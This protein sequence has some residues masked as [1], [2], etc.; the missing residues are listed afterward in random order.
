[1]ATGPNIASIGGLMGDPAR[2]NILTSLMSGH[3]LT[4][5]ELAQ[6]ASIAAATASGHFGQLLEGGLVAAERQGRHRYYRLAGPDVTTAIE[7]LMDLAKLSGKRPVSSRSERPAVAQSTRL[8]RSS[9]RRA[10]CAA[11]LA[12]DTA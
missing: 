2:A 1:M 10:W 12:A 7:V 3:A 9:C 6:V 11:V 8:L 4:A 5:S